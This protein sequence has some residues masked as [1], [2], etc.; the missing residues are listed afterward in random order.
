MMIFDDKDESRP[1][2]EELTFEKQRPTETGEKRKE[3]DMSPIPIRYQKTATLSDALSGTG[4]E[5]Q[6]DQTSLRP[7]EFIEVED[8]VS[9]DTNGHQ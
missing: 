2:A 9:A 3:D 4:H 1:N 7:S 8:I 5:I 6:H